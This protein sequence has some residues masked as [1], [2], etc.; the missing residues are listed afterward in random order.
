MP[1]G[2]GPSAAAA[3]AL[4]YAALSLV[5]FVLYGWDKWQAK[6]EGRRVPELRLHAVALLGGF[7]GA[8]LGMRLFRHKTQK[9]G[10]TVV[11]VA[12][13]L[14]HAASWLGWW[15]YRAR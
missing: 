5:A 10:F 13:A 15:F 12:A 3:V 6:R 4:A 1:E 11:L 9:V 14:L 2:N 7:P 8:W